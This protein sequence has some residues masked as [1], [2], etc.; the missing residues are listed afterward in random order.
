[1]TYDYLR[2]YAVDPRLMHYLI[3]DAEKAAAESTST[4]DLL[5]VIRMLDLA[6]EKLAPSTRYF[7]VSGEEVTFNRADLIEGLENADR[8]VREAIGRL[9]HQSN[10]D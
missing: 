1:V 8:S 5:T 10:S 4:S 3:R 9:K 6:K 2:D 7:N